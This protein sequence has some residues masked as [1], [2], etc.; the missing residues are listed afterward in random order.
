MLHSYRLRSPTPTPALPQPKQRRK[1]VRFIAEVATELEAGEVNSELR[2]KAS[3]EDF[4]VVPIETQI[5]SKARGRANARW[6][7]GALFC[8]QVDDCVEGVG[9]PMVPFGCLTDRA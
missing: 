1:Q 4:H 5:L 3:K 9:H 7:L 8:H 2:G 6:L